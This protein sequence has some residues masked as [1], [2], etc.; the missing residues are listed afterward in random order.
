MP[1]LSLIPVEMKYPKCSGAAPG[2]LARHLF[3]ADYNASRYGIDHVW[4]LNESNGLELS[5][6]IGAASIIPD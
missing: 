1:S 4:I 6:T 2:A 5:C 3:P